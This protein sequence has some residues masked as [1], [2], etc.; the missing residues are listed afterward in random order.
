MGSNREK[1]NLVEKAWEFAYSKEDW[2][3]PLQAALEGV[4]E[5]QAD[6]RPQGAA[7]N[8]IR[9]TVHHLIFYKEAFLRAWRGESG[10]RAEGVTNTDT[11]QAP[12][13]G[14]EG[15]AW[16]ETRRRLEKA[17]ADIASIL[18]EWEDDSSYEK[19]IGS[20]S[21][22]GTWVNSLAVH[23]AYHAGQIIFVRKLQG[24][25]APTRSFS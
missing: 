21:E 16:E 12:A 3:P 5:E 11:F 13:L 14:A 8:T 9:E 17:H 4:T 22:A 20:N 15:A 18:R 7:A 10:A 1:T 2:S 23:D 25:W 6:W 19:R 24:S